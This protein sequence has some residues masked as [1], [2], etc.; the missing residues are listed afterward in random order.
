MEVISKIQNEL[1]MLNGIPKI[2]HGGCLASAILIKRMLKRHG[3]DSELYLISYS[4]TASM[5]NIYHAVVKVGDDL[6]DSNGHY[7][8]ANHSGSTIID[9]DT[10]EE[11]LAADIWNP[12]FDRKFMIDMEIICGE[13]VYERSKDDLHHWL[14]REELGLNA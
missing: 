6:I 10:A 8:R 2:N 4:G 12:D 7:G 9:E 14:R 11:W 1:E 5:R 3:V 13:L